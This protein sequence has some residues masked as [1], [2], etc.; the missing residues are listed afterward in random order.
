V[1]DKNC[2]HCDRGEDEASLMMCRVCKKYACEIHQ[3]QKNGVA[4]CSMDCAIYFFHADPEDPD[5]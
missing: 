1:L 5:E 3:T 4:F 2:R